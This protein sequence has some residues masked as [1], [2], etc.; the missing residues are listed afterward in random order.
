[1]KKVGYKIYNNF[2]IQCQI[3]NRVI[4]EKTGYISKINYSVKNGKCRQV[5]KQKEGEK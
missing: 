3:V 4:A 1:M 5:F 2:C